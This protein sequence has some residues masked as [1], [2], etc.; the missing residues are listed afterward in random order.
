MNREL[1]KLSLTELY[2]NS[3]IGVTFFN[4][5]SPSIPSHPTKLGTQETISTL[6]K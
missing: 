1:M 6:Q 3:L 4:G 2:T 5:G